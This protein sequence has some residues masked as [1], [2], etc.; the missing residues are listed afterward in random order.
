MIKHS[1]DRDLSDDGVAVEVAGAGGGGHPGGG[2]GDLDG[3]LL[4]LPGLLV[5]VNSGGVPASGGLSSSQLC[6]YVCTASN[7]TS[8]FE[9][10]NSL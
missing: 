2:G 4:P 1:N 8:N 7:E 9:T 5:A 3:A 6:F 10:N